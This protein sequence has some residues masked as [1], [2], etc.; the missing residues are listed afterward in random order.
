MLLH[1]NVGQPSAM[2][3]QCWIS[4]GTALLLPGSPAEVAE[5]AVKRTPPGG[6]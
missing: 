3:A 5:S 2:L 1:Y 6:L 4:I